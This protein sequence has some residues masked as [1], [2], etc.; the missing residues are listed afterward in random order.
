MW[1]IPGFLLLL[2]F[3]M[4]TQ[5]GVL[6]QPRAAVALW[7]A[8]AVHLVVTVLTAGSVLERLG[9]GGLLATPWLAAV[10]RWVAPLL[11]TGLAALG[12]TIYVRRG[13][14][15]SIFASFFVFVLVDAVLFSL[16]YLTP[17]LLT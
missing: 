10:A 13:S 11:I 2:V 4:A 9:T 8:I 5:E 14:A 15:R 16:V 3:Y 17:L 6:D 1:A 7:A 12:M